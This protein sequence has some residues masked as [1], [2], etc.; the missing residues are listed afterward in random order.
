MSEQ[1]GTRR[2]RAILSGRV[3]GVGMR[4]TAASLAPRYGLTGWVRNRSDGRVEICAEGLQADLERFMH[5]LKEHMLDYIHDTREVLEP[6]SGG[7]KDFRV[8]Y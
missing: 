3:Q 6:A 2:L 7:W 1:G 8:T 5:S 4:A